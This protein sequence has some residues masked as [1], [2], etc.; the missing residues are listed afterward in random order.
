MNHLDGVHQRWETVHHGGQ[1][2]LVERL[3]QLLQSIQVLQVI[4]GLIGGISNVHIQLTP[5]LQDNITITKGLHRNTTGQANLEGLRFGNCKSGDDSSAR[6]GLDLVN[7]IG[8]FCC[9][10][11]PVLQLSQ[12]AYTCALMTSDYSDPSL[13]HSPESSASLRI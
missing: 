2:I 5:S 7:K 12:R 13:S 9:P 8:E 3:A 11:P 6:L 1:V 10:L 4:L